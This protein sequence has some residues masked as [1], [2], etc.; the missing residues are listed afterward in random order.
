MYSLCYYFINHFLIANVPAH[1]R[2]ARQGEAYSAAGGWGHFRLH[3]VLDCGGSTSLFPWPGL[4]GLPCTRRV[5]PRLFKAAS[6]R[7]TPNFR[8]HQAGLSSSL[9]PNAELLTEERSDDSQQ[10]LV[11]SD[12]VLNFFSGEFTIPEDLSEKSA[13]DALATVN[14]H[15]RA[16]SIG[17]TEEVVTSLDPD[18][19]KAKAS[20][21]LDELNAVEGGKSAHAMTATRWTPTN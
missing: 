8:R 7:R 1:W 20:K 5:E 17:V 19:F 11:R 2:R 4:T 16:S 14:W 12:F 3:S 13:A 10:D 15:H 9:I 21:R 18:D 6:S